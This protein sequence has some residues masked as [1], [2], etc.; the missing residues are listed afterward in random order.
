VS[1]ANPGLPGPPTDWRQTAVQRVLRL[2]AW[3]RCRAARRH[4]RRH[5]QSY[6]AVAFQN[7]RMHELNKMDGSPLAVL[8]RQIAASFAISP[9]LRRTDLGK[10]LIRK[11]FALAVRQHGSPHSKLACRARTGG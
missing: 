7:H 4:V 11:R 6:P 8:G 5:S 9:M 2:P 10:C 1:L 3:T